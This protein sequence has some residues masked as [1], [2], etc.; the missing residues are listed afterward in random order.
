MS[1]WEKFMEQ[2]RVISEKSGIPAVLIYIGLISAVTVVFLG[3]FEEYVTMSVGVLLPALFSLK[4]LASED[5]EDD[6][7]WLT[8]WTVF[9][10]FVVAE[11]FFGAILKF[12]PYY[13]GIKIVFLVWLF[14]P[15][16]QG[17]TFIYENFIYKVFKTVESDIDI[18]VENVKNVT[19]KVVGK[20][21]A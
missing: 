15:N 10:L 8:Y 16:F 21:T 3:I 17:A 2:T 5:K 19:K 11:L 1:I 9:S 6:K 13:F 18:T 12:L 14:L 4:A 20:K 7:Q